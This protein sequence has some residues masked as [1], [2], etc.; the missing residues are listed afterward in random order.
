MKAIPGNNEGPQW[1]NKLLEDLVFIKKH[2]R[3][4]LSKKTIPSAILLAVFVYLGSRMILTVMIISH[5]SNL[6]TTWLIAAFLGISFISIILRYWRTLHFKTI[7]TPFFADENRK[8]IDEFLRSQQLNV[9][10]HPN[11]PEVLQILSRA[12]GNSQQREVMI[13]IAD[14]KRILI[15]SQFINQKWTLNPQ[16][17]NYRLMANRLR[18]WLKIHYPNIKIVLMAQ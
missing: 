2:G 8:L 6:A 4:P 1:N 13:F 10:R 9:Y 15:N 17:R 12:L 11:A 7:P 16:S 18:E 3:Y 5:K 14:D